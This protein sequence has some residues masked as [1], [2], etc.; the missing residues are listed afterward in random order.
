MSGSWTAVPVELIGHSPNTDVSVTTVDRRLT[1]SEL[2]LD[3]IDDTHKLNYGQ[4]VF[5]F[6]FPYGAAGPEFENQSHLPFVKKGIVSLLRSDMIILDG[7]N[8]PG[9]SGG[10]VAFSPIQGE[11]NLRVA[12][13]VSSYEA[14]KDPIYGP[15]GESPLYTWDNTGLIITYSVKYAI[16]LIHENPIGFPLPALNQGP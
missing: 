10:P 13:I 4:D 3:L 5:F 12:S 6:G 11:S 14:V 16:D 2:P 8:N 9:F 1:P 7:H 15:S